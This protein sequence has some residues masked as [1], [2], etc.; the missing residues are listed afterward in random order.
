MLQFE[1][2]PAGPGDCLWLEYG[3]PGNTHIILVDG[4][5]KETFEFLEKRI[6]RAIEER[7]A[8]ELHI[9]LLVVTHIDNDHIKGIL[10]LLN[11]TKHPVTFDDIWFNGSVQLAN[12]P[13]PP[14][15]QTRADLLGK[16]EKN[17]RPD[18]LGLKEGDELSLLLATR[19]MA[20]NIAFDCKAVM[21]PI[22]GKLVTKDF[23][24]GLK[25]TVLGPPIMRLQKL[26]E[27][28][29]TVKYGE[30]NEREDL[31]GPRD[32]WPPVWLNLPSPDDS[33]NNGS[34]IV[35]L[36]EYCNKSLLL[37]GDAIAADI[38][39]GLSRLRFERNLGDHPFPITVFKLPH[40]GSARNISQNLLERI[41]CAQYLISTDG[42]GN[43]RHPDHQA[44]LHVLQHSSSR[45]CLAFNYYAETTRNWRDFR[46]DVLDLGLEIGLRNYDTIY[47]KDPDRGL[48]LAL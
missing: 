34:S 19:E 38:E 40:H 36:A 23:E 26:V 15:E 47:A 27:G 33:V 8:K 10:R 6:G 44:L 1:L 3:E 22:Q 16:I 43:S 12:L 45:P 25:L 31:L 7:G 41:D 14:P 11:E 39:A 13:E 42:T 4:G 21:V 32:T 20:W 37:T 35:L 48:V 18:L 46:Q 28:W 29:K 9:D 2:L 17:P 24:G 5:V 30:P